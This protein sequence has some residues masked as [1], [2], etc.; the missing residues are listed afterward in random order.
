MRETSQLAT[1]LRK[2]ARFLALAQDDKELGPL[3]IS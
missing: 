3:K 1:R 2:I